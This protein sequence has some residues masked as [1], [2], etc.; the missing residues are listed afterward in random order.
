MH[1]RARNLLFVF[2]VVAEA[3]ARSAAQQ[4]PRHVLAYAA[5]GSEL[6]GGKACVV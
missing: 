1:S 3:L 2:G 5:N 4:I 6:Q